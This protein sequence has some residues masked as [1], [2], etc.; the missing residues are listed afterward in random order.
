MK[1]FI[2][3]IWN[4]YEAVRILPPIFFASISLT[5]FLT[6]WAANKPIVLIEMHGVYSAERDK[7]YSLGSLILEDG[8][9]VP[10]NCTNIKERRAIKFEKRLACP[11]HWIPS[12]AVDGLHAEAHLDIKRGR[13]LFLLK[14]NGVEIVG[15]HDARSFYSVE[16]DKPISWYVYEKKQ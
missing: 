3:K 12:E 6:Y 5:Y 13:T 2:M 14:I 15:E 4:R 8:R 7:A 11:E 9:K 1:S 16:P 10:L